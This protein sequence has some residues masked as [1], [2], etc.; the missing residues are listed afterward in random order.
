[1]AEE[2][3]YYL[4]TFWSPERKYLVTVHVTVPRG[5]EC[6]IIGFQDDDGV[7]WEPASEQKNVAQLASSAGEDHAKG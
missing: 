4:R 1:M 2:P 5:Q 7:E 6:N 3:D